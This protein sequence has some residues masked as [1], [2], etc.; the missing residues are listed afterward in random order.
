M[1][2]R[3]ELRKTLTSVTHESY[4]SGVPL[5]KINYKQL[6]ADHIL[7]QAM[8]SYHDLFSID[9]FFKYINASTTVINTSNVK[10]MMRQAWHD[11]KGSAAEWDVYCDINTM[12]GSSTAIGRRQLTSMLLDIMRG[13]LHA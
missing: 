11:H 3:N 9:Y 2:T 5:A 10:S 12:L 4:A 1:P 13:V 6:E 8:I 7:M